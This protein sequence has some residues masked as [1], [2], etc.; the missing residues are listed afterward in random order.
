MGHT[1]D[2]LTA[3]AN[4]I[5]SA[6]PQREMDMLLTTGERQTAALMTMALAGRGIEAIRPIV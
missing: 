4:A 5:S 3:K 6:P 1:T 2:E